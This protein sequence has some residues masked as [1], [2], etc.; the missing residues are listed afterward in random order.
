MAGYFDLALIP[1]QAE[2]YFEANRNVMIIEDD[3]ILGEMIFESLA[4]IGFEVSRATN[5]PMAFEQLQQ[6]S[7]D[8]ILLDLLLPE[9][10]G[11]EIYSRLQEDPATEAIPVIIISAWA[12]ERNRE[13]AAQLGIRYFLAKPF[14]EDEL[15]YTILTVLIDQA[16]E[17]S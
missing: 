4:D 17:E 16:H 5:G 1:A 14:T 2:Q 9:M 8:F 13:K 3:K 7:V 15:L 11:F 6:R 10:D 12:D